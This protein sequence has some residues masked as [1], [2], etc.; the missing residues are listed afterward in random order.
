R[1]RRRHA[2]HPRDFAEVPMT[3]ALR[4]DAPVICDGCGRQV[5]RRARQQ[6]FCSTRCR[7]KARTCVRAPAGRPTT[8]PVKNNERTAVSAREPSRK[9]N[10]IKGAQTR[11]WAPKHVLDVEVWG[12]RTWQSAISSGGIEIEISRVRAR[13]LVDCNGGAS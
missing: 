2:R 1:Q 6:R 11:I 8:A 10:E 4:R 3:R 7:E 9:F 5:A 13:A 12:G